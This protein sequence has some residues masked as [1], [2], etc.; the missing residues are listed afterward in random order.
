MQGR[1]ALWLTLG[2][3]MFAAASGVFAFLT[4]YHEATEFMDDELRQVAALLERHKLPIPEDT[5]VSELS[6][7]IKTKTAIVV[8]KLGSDAVGSL[9]PELPPD[10]PGGLQTIRSDGHEWRLFVTTRQ[11]GER[12]AAGQRV[13]LRNDIARQGAVAALLSL[14]LVMGFAAAGSCLIIR[15]VF[16]PVRALAKLVDQRED[17]DLTL[18]E[19]HHVPSE[20]LPFLEAVNRMLT[21]VNRA[22]ETQRRFVADAAHELRSPLTALSLQAEHL[23]AADMSPQARE[24]LARL[25]QGL[26]RARDLLAQLLALARA[27]ANPREDMRAESLSLLLRQ[28]LEDMMPL[29]E[30]RNIDLGVLS[31]DEA[32]IQTPPHALAVI[33][34]NLLDNAIRYTP[35]GG[36]VDIS[37]SCADESVI[38]VITDT[39]PGIPPAE[40]E[41]VFE[42]FYR[43]PGH[44]V[45][46]S[47]PGLAIAKTLTTQ[48]GGTIHLTDAPEGPG[49]R[50][51]A[52]F[53]TR[54]RLA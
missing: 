42:P 40:R 44:D 35:P 31:L 28:I 47:G 30:A 8:R 7:S 12:F 49:L 14:L 13:I 18:L 34:K 37:A 5:A 48:L 22:V 3:L 21:R 6:S 38:L 32:T 33:L 45:T 24:R 25:G 26:N 53:P 29:A 23:A 54:L 46:G 52:R 11:P 17:L 16:T 27:Q 36:R 20:I 41:R 1:L 39:G 2:I 19:T 50:V 9:L 15:H 43:L 51:I 4:V 10:M